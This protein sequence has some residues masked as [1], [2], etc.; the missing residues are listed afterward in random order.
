MET[1]LISHAERIKQQLISTKS[2]DGGTMSENVAVVPVAVEVPKLTLGD[3]I[4]GVNFVNFEPYIT[5]TVSPFEHDSLPDD[6]VLADG[7]TYSLASPLRKANP[8]K[9]AAAGVFREP[10]AQIFQN[11]NELFTGDLRYFGDVSNISSKIGEVC[12]SIEDRL[13][14]V[15]CAAN[16]G[17]SSFTVSLAAVK[18]EV[19]PASLDDGEEFAEEVGEESAEEVMEFSFSD[20]VSVFVYGTLVDESTVRLTINVNL[21]VPLF[22]KGKDVAANLG[23]INRILR[24]MAENTIGATNY[25]LLYTLSSDNLL[26][27]GTVQLLTDLQGEESDVSTIGVPYLRDAVLN[28]ED[29]FGLYPINYTLSDAIESIFA[30]GGDIVLVIN[31]IASKK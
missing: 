21:V 7:N 19:L 18:S 12:I 4:T 11:V 6:V 30:Y 5:L 23:V 22:A 26:S 14:S 16:N 25:K 31:E 2:S 10:L 13:N 29:P 27:P 9:G 17:D 3:L 8:Q 15:I 20:F 28:G 24:T 1:E